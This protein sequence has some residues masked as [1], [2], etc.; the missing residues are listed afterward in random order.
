V[1]RLKN[2]FRFQQRICT[3]ALA[4]DL[5]QPEHRNGKKLTGRSLKSSQR[6]WAQRY[7]WSAMNGQCVQ[8]TFAVLK[9]RGGMAHVNSPLFSR[10][11]RL[12]QMDEP[13]AGI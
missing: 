8:M 4:Q 3:A 1:N 2:R 6:T 10:F 13:L 5:A 11:A 7:G 12:R 9:G